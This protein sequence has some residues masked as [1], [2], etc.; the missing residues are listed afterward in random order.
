MISL[1]QTRLDAPVPCTVQVSGTV[2]SL[3]D[4]AECLPALISTHEHLVAKHMV[5]KRWQLTLHVHLALPDLPDWTRVH[6]KQS[7]YHSLFHGEKE[8]R[9]N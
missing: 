2:D 1:V 8:C 3:H 7:Y 4:I 5:A 6:G 9:Y